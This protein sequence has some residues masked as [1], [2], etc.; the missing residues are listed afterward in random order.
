M[1]AARR[2]LAIYVGCYLLFLYAPILMLPLFSLDASPAMGFPIRMLTLHWYALLARDSA[3]WAALFASVRVA[4]VASVTATLAGLLAAYAL[5]RGRGVAARPVAA[6][7]AAPLLIPGVVLGVAILITGRLLG[8]A[9]S[10]PMVAF[11][12][13]VICLPLCLIVLRS[14]FLQTGRAVEDAALDLGAPPSMVMLRVVLPMAAPSLVSCLLLS[15][16]TSMD[17]FVVSFFLA[18]R[19]QT[20]PIFIW[21]HLRFPLE[22]PRMMA[23]GTLLLAV[24]TTLA[25]LAERLSLRPSAGAGRHE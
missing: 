5:V 9:P 11:G 4:V 17:E 1:T 16:T 20:L 15:F 18:G 23:L 3:V 12:H 10:L 6:L 7:A 21:N 22:L 24:S 19:Q 13:V 8:L 25:L 14:H 2:L